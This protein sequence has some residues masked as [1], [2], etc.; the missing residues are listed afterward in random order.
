MNTR[1]ASLAL[2]GA[3]ASMVLSSCA[4]LG[5]ARAPQPAIEIRNGGHMVIWTAYLRDGDDPAVVR[6]MVRRA[7]LWRG[8]V[9]G[10]IDVTAYG[11]DGQVLARR[12]ARWS[13]SLG[14]AHATSAPFHAK[15]GV[16]RGDVTRLR[17]AFA[18]GKHKD[19]ETFQ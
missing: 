13:G 11:A 17:V 1:L 10:H 5:V 19:S 8:P 15:L 7:L 14:G 18:P 4:S 16:P 9:T 6:G 3:T 12:A 2:A